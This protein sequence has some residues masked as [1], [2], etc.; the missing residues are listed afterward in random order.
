LGVELDRDKLAKY[1]ELYKQ[2]GNYAYDRDPKRPQ[3][4]SVTPERNWA[5]PKGKNRTARREGRRN[6]AKRM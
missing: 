4:F 1:A 2:L 5:V 6:Q 3:W